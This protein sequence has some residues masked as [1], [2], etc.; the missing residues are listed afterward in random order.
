[1]KF[2]GENK[3]LIWL[4]YQMAADK[5]DKFSIPQLC[6]KMLADFK[7]EGVHAIIPISKKH[8]EKLQADY[9][10]DLGDGPGTFDFV[11]VDVSYLNGV[12]QIHDFK[13]LQKRTDFKMI[14]NTEPFQSRALKS[15]LAKPAA[16]FNPEMVNYVLF[17]P[18]EDMFTKE[19][20]YNV[21]LALMMNKA[22]FNG[23]A[24]MAQSA[25]V[26]R[27]IFS[28]TLVREAMEKNWKKN[29]LGINCSKIDKMRE[30]R[31]PY[32][33]GVVRFLYGGRL[34]HHK[35]IED[36]IE[37]IKYLHESGMKV[38]YTIQTYGQNSCKKLEGWAKEYP[39]IK[40]LYNVPQAE[41]Y[42]NA[43]THDVFICASRI[44]TYGLSFFEMLYS[45]MVGV[46]YKQPWQMGILP[47]DYELVAANKNQLMAM[48]KDVAS[49]LVDWQM[50]T[51]K[52]KQMIFDNENSSTK[53]RELLEKLEAWAEV[54]K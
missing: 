40:P 47:A 53:N 5:W 1:M 39:F 20:K 49:N 38:E 30:D 42:K 45:G 9:F 22:I 11:D 37:V 16:Y 8:K 23:P 15:G 27:Q 51:L 26:A 50:K 17:S 12:L 29:S 36:T 24:S 31:V 10:S 19:E 13:E 44:E 34:S 43:L 6:K 2:T 14:L 28:P 7:K 21:V 3:L 54:I 25:A 33:D 32:D 4:P 48:T 18:D 52:Y 41:F 35:H 46:F